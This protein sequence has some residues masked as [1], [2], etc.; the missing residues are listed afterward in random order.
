MVA[1][2]ALSRVCCRLSCMCPGNRCH[3]IC[4]LLCFFF[5]EWNF[6]NFC[7]IVNYTDPC[8]KLCFEQMFMSHRLGRNVQN[9][10]AT[11]LCATNSRTGCYVTPQS[12]A[13]ALLLNT[14]AKTCCQS[15]LKGSPFRVFSSLA[16]E[17]GLSHPKQLPFLIYTSGVGSL[18]S[19]HKSTWSSLITRLKS[20]P[21]HQWCFSTLIFCSCD[22]SQL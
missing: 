14:S 2:A 7:M 21:W 1:I 19:L 18:D 13:E 4:S 17:P 12:H 3:I 5:L 16:A 8:Y 10:W 15:K 9:W 22:S 6:T 20:T 11:L